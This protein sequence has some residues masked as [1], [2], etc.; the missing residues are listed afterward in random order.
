MDVAGTCSLHL[1][2]SRGW[3]GT[4]LRATA[5]AAAAA[6]E[7][8]LVVAEDERSRAAVVGGGSGDGSAL[9]AAI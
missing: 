9:D 7:A 6:L 5:A 4:R 2:V 3:Q 1:R 8:V